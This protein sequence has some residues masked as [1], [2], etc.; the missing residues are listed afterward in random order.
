[1]LTRKKVIHRTNQDNCWNLTTWQQ[2]SYSLDGA[3]IM[4]YAKIKQVLNKHPPLPNIFGEDVWEKQ[5]NCCPNCLLWNPTQSTNQCFG[6]THHTCRSCVLTQVS[7]V[8]GEHYWHFWCN[9]LCFFP[10]GKITGL[11]VTGL[12]IWLLGS[13][14]MSDLIAVLPESYKWVQSVFQLK[15]QPKL[16]LTQIILYAITTLP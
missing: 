6:P 8:T 1:M 9:H 11:F 7:C 5:L 15:W 2:S 14:A 12:N 13:I 3:R 16:T 10:P 4:S